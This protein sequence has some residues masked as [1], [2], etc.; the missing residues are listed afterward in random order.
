MMD[1]NKLAE[2]CKYSSLQ[3][4]LCQDH[5]VTITWN[6]LIHNSTK[7]ILHIYRVHSATK[8]GIKKERDFLSHLWFT[9]LCFV[10]SNQFRFNPTRTQCIRPPHHKSYVSDRMYMYIHTDE[11]TQRIYIQCALE[12]VTFSL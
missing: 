12:P 2:N 11:L 3:F 7:K 9:S 10:S 8:K 4:S 6:Y 5:R 1:W